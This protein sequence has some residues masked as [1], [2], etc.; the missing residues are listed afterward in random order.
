MKKEQEMVKNWVGIAIVFFIISTFIGLSTLFPSYNNNNNNSNVQRITTDESEEVE[1]YSVFD[2]EVGTGK[3]VVIGSTVS[4]RYVG[5]IETNDRI[6]DSNL[7]VEQE[8]LR[9]RVGDGT[10]IEGFERGVI[11]AKEGGV[12]FITIQ[13]EAGYGLAGNLDAGITADDTIIFLVSI[14]SVE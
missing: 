13:P 5:F 3:E 1:P 12:R 11:G 4:V 9:F 6:F 8:P 10:L 2:Q 7:D 14:E